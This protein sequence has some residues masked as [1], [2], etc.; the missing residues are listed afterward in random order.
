MKEGERKPSF[1]ALNWLKIKQV[2]KETVRYYA[3]SHLY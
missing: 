1:I 3:V 2:V